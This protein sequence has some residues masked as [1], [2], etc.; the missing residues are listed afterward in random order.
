MKMIELATAVNWIAI[1]ASSE[2]TARPPVKPTLPRTAPRFFR[3]DGASS[4]SAAVKAVVAAPE[5]KP[6]TMRPTITH[7]I[8]GARRNIRFDAS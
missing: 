3:F 7:P 5:A 6:W 1:P 8:S 2:P 4:T